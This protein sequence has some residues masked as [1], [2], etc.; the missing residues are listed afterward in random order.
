MGQKVH[1]LGLRLGIVKDWKSRWFAKK[2]YAHMVLEDAAIREYFKKRF[3]RSDTG[4]GRRDRARD[5]GIAEVEIERAANN[6]RITLHTA[7]PGIIIGRGGRGIDDLRNELERLTNRKVH[8][9]V[10]EVRQSEL[11]AQLVAEN[12]A[13][14][15]E[16]RVAFKRTVHQAVQRSM[17]MGAQGIKIICAGRLGGSEMARRYPDKDGK[18]PLHTLRA[19]IDYGFT[20]ARTTAGNIGIKVWIYRGD[21]IPEKAP[22]RPEVPAEKREQKKRPGWRRVPQAEQA[23]EVEAEAAAEQAEEAAAEAVAPAA[24]AEPAEGA[25]EAAQAADESAPATEDVADATAPADDAEAESTPDTE[26]EDTDEE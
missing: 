22:A 10:E 1:P 25:A 18:I 26:N 20:E 4:R 5:A 3:V 14:Q 9:N 21:I 17:R 15:L 12:V 6:V 23:P 16:K 2:G 19:D 7:K 11:N 24:A 13:G 8:I